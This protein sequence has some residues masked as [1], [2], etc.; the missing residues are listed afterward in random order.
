MSEDE[1]IG[2][3]ETDCK[4]VKW[5][6][7]VVLWKYSGENEEKMERN[8]ILW[9]VWN[10]SKRELQYINNRLVEQTDVKNDEKWDR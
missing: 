9:K 8:S 1:C 10:K 6:G 4:G 3:G 2:I 5:K 7:I